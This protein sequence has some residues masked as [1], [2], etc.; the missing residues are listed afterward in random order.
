MISLGS[1]L[2]SY[3]PKPEVINAAVENFLFMDVAEMLPLPHQL[4][5]ACMMEE[6]VHGLMHVQDERL[7]SVIV[8]HLYPGVVLVDGRYTV[9]P[10]ADPSSGRAPISGA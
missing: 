6:F 10:E 2:L 5:V 8:A 7:T 4:Q 3:N 9:A 1:G